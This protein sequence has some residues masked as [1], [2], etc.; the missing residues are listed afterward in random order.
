M[1]GTILGPDGKPRC[2]WCGAAPEFFDYH[3]TE[4]GL[5]VGDDHR[6][7]EKLCLEGFQSG[8]SWR[9]I[10]A[11]RENF[12]A[13]F[14]N[15]DFDKIARYARRDVDRLLKDEGI[16]RHRGKIEAVV[17]NARRARELVKQE[18]SLAAFIW[19]Y[20]PDAAQLPKPQTASTSAASLA[21]S[22][23]L[24]KQGWKFV[25]P[26]TVHAFMQAMGLVNDHVE[27]CAIRAKVER[28][29]KNFRRPGR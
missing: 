24:K 8:L 26:T 21:L 23:D 13:A 1:S 3:D 9:T 4:W 16:V 29:R 2:R 18:G 19:R 10:L 7:F 27:D 5:P 25:G 15:F 20:E 22:K 6:L 14:D 12:R 28:A 17:N 11:K